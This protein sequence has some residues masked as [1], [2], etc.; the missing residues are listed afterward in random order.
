M[1]CMWSTRINS[2]LFLESSLPES[3]N[4]AKQP[5]KKQVKYKRYC[6]FHLYF[7]D[8]YNHTLLQKLSP[9]IERHFIGAYA[10]V[11]VKQWRITGLS[12]A[13]KPQ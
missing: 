12:L 2:R 7:I 9:L 11:Q 13:G 8:A 3:D 10:L 5:I 6:K 4:G 1:Q